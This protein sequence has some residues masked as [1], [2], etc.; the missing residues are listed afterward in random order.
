[1]ADPRKTEKPTG[2]RRQEA[3]KKGQT[4]RTPELGQWLTI[5]LLSLAI[6][7]L[8]KHE[9]RVWEDTMSGCFRAIAD[10]QPAV[11][12][13]PRQPRKRRLSLT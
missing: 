4:P 5:L 3:R 8:L 10:P 1:M 9:I 6:G 2:K 11:A 7:P 12:L 13:K